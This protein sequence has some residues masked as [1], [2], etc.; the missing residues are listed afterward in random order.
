MFVAFDDYIVRCIES[1]IL[2]LQSISWP[3]LHAWLIAV[4][5]GSAEHV[6]HRFAIRHIRRCN[7]YSL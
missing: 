3:R 5:L 6:L 7:G 2:H 1:N 4:I